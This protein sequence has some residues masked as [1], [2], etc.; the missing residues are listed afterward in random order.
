MRK[1]IYI[2]LTFCLVG[3]SLFDNEDPIPAY[4][5][6]ED[7][8]LSTLVA[9]GANTHN[10]TDV[11]VFSGQEL[12]GIFPLPA[13][14]PVII[15]GSEK[16]FTI[17][18]GVRNNGTQ[19]NSLRYPFFSPIE[20]TLDLEAQE[21]VRVPMEFSY[22]TETKFDLVEGFE[23]NHQFSIEPSGAETTPIVISTDMVK[24]GQGSGHVHMDTDTS[25]FERSTIA[26]FQKSQNNGF[27]TFVELDYKCD[28]PFLV[29]YIIR[30][31]QVIS[32]QYTVLVAPSDDWNKIYIDLSTPV[33][34]T[35]VETYT[36]SLASSVTTDVNL[37]ADIYLDNI[38][39]LHF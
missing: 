24:T 35:N 30:T 34:G 20:V 7:P 9:Q 16:D 33:A 26:Q 22:T 36:I 8:T 21:E 38:K 25:T 18:A 12:L 5:V 17:F 32:K 28:I 14:V 4:L 19:S 3:C 6:L 15:D 11:W 27:F 23:G 39:L 1:L 13:K 10:I 29:G 2:A 37:P 31:N